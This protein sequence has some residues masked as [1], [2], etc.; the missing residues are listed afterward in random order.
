MRGILRSGII[1]A[2]FTAALWI[3]EI[4]DQV[5][6]AGLDQYGLI[7]RDPDHLAGI[8]TMPLL[9][10]G[11]GHLAA[12]TVPLL[13]LGL[14]AAMRGLARFLAATGIIVILGGLLLW[15]AGPANTLTVG[16]SGLIFGYFGY[17]LGR[18]AFERR[19]GDIVL[20]VIMVVVYGSILWGVL[21]GDPGISWQGHLF[22]FIA[23]VA[24]AFALRRI[25]TPRTTPKP[26]TV[27]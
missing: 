27:G 13:V 4:I 18:G 5:G 21:P 25:G 10:A 24:A 12:N 26:P 9:H 8:I 14:A 16:A 19:I 7:P 11:F 15:L 23:G 2:V 17:I 3:L 22:G 20:A 6:H 1:L